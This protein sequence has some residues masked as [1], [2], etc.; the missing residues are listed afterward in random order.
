MGDPAV[1]EYNG[2][3]FRPPSY[4]S[5]NILAELGHTEAARVE[6]YN[7][8]RFGAAGGLWESWGRLWPWCPKWFAEFAPKE[9]AAKADM[10]QDLTKKFRHGITIIGL[11]AEGEDLI[12]GYLDHT[13]WLRRD[14]KIR[15]QESK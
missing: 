2:C 11:T 7:T 15:A 3:G 10:I 5:D 1:N 8:Y 14:A 13:K 6:A 12:C 9:A 4:N